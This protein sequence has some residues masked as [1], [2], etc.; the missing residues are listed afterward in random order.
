MKNVFSVF[1]IISVFFG[2]I[3]CSGKKTIEGDRHYEQGEYNKALDAYNK[4][5]KVYPRN[6]KTLYNRARTYEQLGNIENAKKDLD[7]LLELDP[8]HLMG[9]ITLGELEFKVAD[10][11]RAFYEFDLAV[12]NHK[13]N[14][15]A[16]AYRAKANQ[17]LGKIRKALADYG[18][19][20]QLD[21]KN[22]MAYLYRGTLYV[23]QKKSSSACNDFRKARDLKVIE[24]ERALSKYCKN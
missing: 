4:Y 21:P 17:K 18:T 9:R 14:S 19:A 3:S 7:K 11:K 20:I 6:K 8:K 1:L 12:T 13:Q 10:Y 22:G 15:S 16:Y 24:A 23:S 5:L 2:M